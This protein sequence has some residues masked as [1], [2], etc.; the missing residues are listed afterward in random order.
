MV[1]E[2]VCRIVS[3]T[4]HFDVELLHKS[5]T[6]IFLGLELCGTFLID[7]ACGLRVQLLIYIK[8][9]RKLEM[10]PV[11]KRIPHRIWNCFRP[12]LELLIAAASTGYE[13]FRNSVSTH[14]APFVVV[15]SEPYLGEILELVVVG[16]H[17]WDEVAVVVDDRHV[18]C[19]LMIKLASI[20]IC[21][22]EVFVDERFVL[23]HSV[24]F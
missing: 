2:S 12:F 13:F 18:L 22:H 15:A 4:N 8:T 20:V 24:D 10:C 7:S 11:I 9:S 16:N 6:T 5:L 21:E 1:F 23:D 3:G 14:R 19:A 17:L